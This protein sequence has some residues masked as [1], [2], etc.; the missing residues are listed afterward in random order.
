[1]RL[2][3]N[4][5]A[6]CVVIAVGVGGVL[7][8]SLFQ[9]PLMHQASVLASTL[10]PVP[11]ATPMPTPLPT[12]APTPEPTP[13]VETVRFSATGDNLIHDGI[14]LQARQR[15]ENGSYDFTEAYEPMRTFYEQFDVNWLNQETL[16]NDAFEP[17]G[18][19]LFST[20][21]DITDALYDI[22]FR[23][24]SVSN[25]HSYDKGAEG[26]ISS[27]EHWAAMPDDVAVAGFYNQETYDD[28]T[29]QTVNGITFG[30]LSYT[31][32]TNGLP[33][34]SESEYRVIYLDE[35]DLISQQIADMRPNCDV[36]V[37]SCHWGV[38]GSHELTDF[39]TE[40]AQWLAD[41]GVDLIIGT[42]PHVTQTA[43]WLTGSGG[44]TTFVA[45]S[46][47]NFLNA[48]SQPDN[49]VGAVLDITFQKTTQ[50]DGSVSV[51]MLNPKLHG[52]VTQYEAGYQDI[53]VY[54]YA[55]Y[56]DELGAAHG[57]FTL[58]RTQIEEIL[59]SSIDSEFLTLD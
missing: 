20:P 39:Q 26:I 58:S 16:V 12:P 53:R 10:L 37:V 46:L 45:Y 9:D 27:L 51:E 7:I 40:T 4:E 42:H 19:P 2:R 59:S 48:Q 28:Y 13:T 38:E 35:R 23:V 43:Q 56:T 50:P 36:L 24:F 6:A 54:P 15:G 57:N 41:Q 5:I 14:F 29:Y 11:T 1:M 3:N 17:S 55:D 49:M 44:N 18:Y 32:Y 34:P 8:G 25:N 30:Y 52:V 31:E 21:G 22:G 33:T 47:G